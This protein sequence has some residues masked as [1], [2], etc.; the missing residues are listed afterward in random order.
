MYIYVCIC[1]WI[2]DAFLLNILNS[3]G[4]KLLCCFN[5][6]TNWIC[7][8]RKLNIKIKHKLHLIFFLFRSLS[9]GKH[10]SHRE[11]LSSSYSKAIGFGVLDIPLRDFCDPLTPQTPHL[12]LYLYF[13]NLGMI[14]KK[15]RHAGSLH[16][17]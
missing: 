3:S 8:K 17:K 4:R 9:L 11:N 5:I 14:K 2:F 10:T 6:S 16:E 1:I 15:K 13:K 7:I 12:C